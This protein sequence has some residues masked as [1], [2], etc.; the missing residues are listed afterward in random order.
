MGWIVEGDDGIVGFNDVRLVKY[1]KEICAK[2]NM[3]IDLEIVNSEEIEFCK[4]NVILG[5]DLAHS[6][7]FKTPH[8]LLYKFGLSEHFRG[9]Y[10]TK[11]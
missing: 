5:Q 6:V 4:H 1:A 8:N 2:L 3:V 9:D 11:G 7:M 10:G